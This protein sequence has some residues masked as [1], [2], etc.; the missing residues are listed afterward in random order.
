MDGREGRD[1]QWATQTA[2]GDA[3]CCICSYVMRCAEFP[4]VGWHAQGLSS[5]PNPCSAAASAG[6][7]SPAFAASASSSSGNIYFHQQAS[8][9]HSSPFGFIFPF[10]TLG[11][12][13]L[14]HF[15]PSTSQFLSAKTLAF[16]PHP[17]GH[18]AVD[19]AAVEG[20][21]E[22]TCVSSGVDCGKELAFAAVFVDVT[23][24]V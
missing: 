12:T 22:V 11:F 9:D 14:S 6:S 20:R 24:G 7:D 4:A 3:A 2:T 23:R 18:V 21:E 19:I 1:V 16:A 17:P 15:Q 10:T 13:R 5:I 8:L